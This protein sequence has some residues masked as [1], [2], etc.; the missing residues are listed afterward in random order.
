LQSGE[1]FATFVGLLVQAANTSWPEAEMTKKKT[2][3]SGEPAAKTKAAGGAG[4]APEAHAEAT[5]ASA[6][7]AADQSRAIDLKTQIGK[8]DQAIAKFQGGDFQAARK[9][10]EAALDGPNLNMSHTARMHISMCDQRLSKLNVE[11]KT[12]EDQYNYAVTLMNAR[13]HAKAVEHLRVALAADEGADHVH[14]A[15][16]LCLGLTGD[17]QGAL[18][19]LRRAVELDPSNRNLA[20]RDPDFMEVARESPLREYLIPEHAE[21]V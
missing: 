2:A 7:A 13:Q 5:T 8:F 14:Y 18:Q 10:F 6:G 15:L 17:R 4:R 21:S 3:R 11:L 20:R 16:A 9:L 12:P 19:H 1:W